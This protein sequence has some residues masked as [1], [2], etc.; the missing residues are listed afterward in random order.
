LLF[1]GRVI[2][3]FLHSAASFLA[4]NSLPFF[5]FFSL[6]LNLLCF[7]SYFLFASFSMSVFYG[8]LYTVNRPAYKK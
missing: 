6:F 7:S 1:L 5:L 3:C 2:P 4:W 8:L